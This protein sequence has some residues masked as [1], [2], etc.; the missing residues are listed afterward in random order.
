MAKKVVM[1]K[2]PPELKMFYLQKQ[3]N[4]MNQVKATT[5]MRIPISMMDVKRYVAIK[6][7]TMDFDL[8]LLEKVIGKKLR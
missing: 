2:I 4:L 3:E 7:P 6:N 1:D 5:G 8:R